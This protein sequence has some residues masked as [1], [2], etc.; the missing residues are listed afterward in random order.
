MTNTCA[1]THTH[2]HTHT[3][4]GGGVKEVSTLARVYSYIPGPYPQELSSTCL[5]NQT[6]FRK[7]YSCHLK[8]TGSDIYII[9]IL[10]AQVENIEYFKTSMQIFVLLYSKLLYGY[11]I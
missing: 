1:R 5:D 7:Q 2:I 11:N 4:I 8:I 9:Y 6:I 3:H 10:F